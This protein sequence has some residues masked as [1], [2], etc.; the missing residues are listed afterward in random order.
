[1]RWREKVLSI[2]QRKRWQDRL[3][4]LSSRSAQSHSSYIKS[5]NQRTTAEVSAQDDIWSRCVDYVILR[6]KDKS[7]FLSS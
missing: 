4:I 1:M 7:S 3:W 5:F 6:P 2:V